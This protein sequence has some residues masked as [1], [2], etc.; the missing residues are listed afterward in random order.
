MKRREFLG[1][2]V[3]FGAGLSASGTGKA[4]A[5][6]PRSGPA[7]ASSRPTAEAALELLLEGNER[8]VAGRSSHPHS[9]K[10]WRDRLA[11][12]QHPIATILTCSD[13]R[14][15]PELLFDRGFGDLF[16]VRVAG[17]IVTR[18]GIGTLEYAQHHLGT[19]LYMVLGHEG[20]G[21]VTAALLPKEK[22]EA[23]PRGVREL[24][25]LVHV[26][27]VDPQ[28][29]SE[30][31]L[32]AAVEANARHSAQVLWDLDPEDEG[33]EPREGEMLVSAVYELGT[34]RV[35]ILQK[36]TGPQAE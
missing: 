8:F 7:S 26:G 14:V 35:R 25:D 34:G 30:A 29:D 20:C 19:P 11:R 18:F 16:I 10:G 28:A 5:A 21:A 36:Y 32:A 24:L 33:F 15:P 22:R 9:T 2:A 12:D 31:R 23:E 17:N 1:A 4:L 13:S 6:S 3:A 27:K